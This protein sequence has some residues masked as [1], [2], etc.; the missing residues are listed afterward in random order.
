MSSLHINTAALQ[1]YVTKLDKIGKNAIPMAA[2]NALYDT[3]MDVKQVTMPASAGSEFTQRRKN[4]FSANSKF[5]P[6]KGLD[7]STMQASVG[8][9]E[10]KLSNTSTNYAVK[11]LQQQEH[12]GTIDSKAFIPMKGAR[13]GAKGN[14]RPNARL[15]AMKSK[16]VVARNLSAGKSKGEKFLNAVF[17]A[18]PGGFVLGS[19]KRGENILW[20]VN[21]LSS[22]INTHDLD[23]TPL[24]DYSK[25]RSI[26]VNQ[27][28]FMKEASEKSAKKMPLFFLKQAKKQLQKYYGT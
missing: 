16:V 28:N 23:L 7:L 18:G 24:Y 10:N 19:T 1:K 14:I 4:F 27:T 3:V 17:K 13:A 5:I 15:S 8:F 25:G 12:G 6:A 26:H 9:Y 22:N 11:D 2:R 20:R 21:S